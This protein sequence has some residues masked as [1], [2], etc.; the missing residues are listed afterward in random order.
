LSDLARTEEDVN[1]YR[2]A[3]HQHY[4]EA[5]MMLNSVNPKD[6]VKVVFV[7]AVAPMCRGISMT[8]YVDI[9]DISQEQVRQVYENYYR[10]HTF[11]K[12]S[13]EPPHTSWSREVTT[14]LSMRSLIRGRGR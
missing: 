4:V 6:P 5:E 10:G 9:G 7:P 12:M 2:V 13:G 11:V 1:V 14:A 3:T 8:S